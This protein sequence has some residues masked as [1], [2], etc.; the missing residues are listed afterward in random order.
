MA[1]VHVTFIYPSNDGTKLWEAEFSTEELIA[2]VGCDEIT[3]EGDTLFIEKRV[4]EQC[5]DKRWL[6]IYLSKNI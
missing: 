6:S 3:T 5:H 4:F 1:A 2:L